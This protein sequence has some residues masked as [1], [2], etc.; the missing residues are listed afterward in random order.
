MDTSTD[1]VLQNISNVVKLLPTTTVLAFQTLNPSFTNYGKCLESNKILTLSFIISSAI[2][3]AFFSITD[4]VMHRGKLYYGLA[5]FNGLYVFNINDKEAQ[6][7]RNWFKTHCNK[8]YK[9]RISD[10]VHVFF[11]VI[12]FLTICIGDGFIQTCFFSESDENEMQWLI[13]LPLAF[14]LLATIVFLL[15]PTSRKGIGYSTDTETILEE[16]EEDQPKS[17]SPSSELELELPVLKNINKEYG[18]NN[19]DCVVEMLTP[20][21]INHCRLCRSY[22]VY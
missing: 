12:V 2:T 3:C 7:V 8:R 16:E 22:T 20:H 13:N 5:T 1:K 15:M 6:H 21:Q 18:K 4:S 14:S 19:N 9:L 10:G 17:N 11:T